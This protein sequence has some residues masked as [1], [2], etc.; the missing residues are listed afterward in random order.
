MFLFCVTSVWKNGLLMSGYESEATTHLRGIS[1]TFLQNQT[2]IP[3]NREDGFILPCACRCEYT[4]LP[5]DENGSFW[6]IIA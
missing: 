6:M 2:G 1:P 5:S 4:G 3:E